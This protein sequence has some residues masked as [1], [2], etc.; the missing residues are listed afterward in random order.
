MHGGE[1]LA[2]LRAWG[3]RQKPRC[4]SLGQEVEA[5]TKFSG[6]LVCRPFVVITLGRLALQVLDTHRLCKGN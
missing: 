4:D 2:A 1:N 5:G 3:L 6:H